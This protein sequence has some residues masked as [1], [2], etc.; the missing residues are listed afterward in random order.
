MWGRGPALY[1]HNYNKRLIVITQGLLAKICEA[2]I[3][4]AHKML[5]ML[6]TLQYEYDRYRTI[7]DGLNSN[8]KLCINGCQI[9]KEFKSVN[10]WVGRTQFMK[11]LKSHD[12][13]PLSV[14]MFT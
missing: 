9:R 7:R 4:S 13:C 5:Y 11:N 14:I 8:M 10:K 3:D 12:S 6:R 1:K 2:K